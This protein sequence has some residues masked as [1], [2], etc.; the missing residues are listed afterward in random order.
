VP[1]TFTGSAAIAG[2][3]HWLK[4]HAAA[5]CDLMS[6]SPCI[7]SLP[8]ARDHLE[9]CDADCAAIWMREIHRWYENGAACVAVSES[10]PQPRETAGGGALATG[11]DC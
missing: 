7:V 1:S 10:C 9:V 4:I 5:W 2:S 8:A 3:P 6:H 11:N